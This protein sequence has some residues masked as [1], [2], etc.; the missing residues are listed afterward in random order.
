MPGICNAQAYRLSVRRR[1]AVRRTAGSGA[2]GAHGRQLDLA[3]A[4]LAVARGALTA[5]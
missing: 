3:V 1:V 2:G 5:L 4:E